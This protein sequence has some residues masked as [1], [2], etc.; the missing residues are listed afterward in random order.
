MI[1]KTCSLSK[2][3][4]VASTGRNPHNQVC[5]HDIIA[6]F[7]PPRRQPTTGGACAL[8]L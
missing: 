8:S 4:G 6:P 3:G 7:L 2:P 1:A 5:N